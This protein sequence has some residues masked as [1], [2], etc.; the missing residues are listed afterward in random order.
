MRSRNMP[1][2]RFF[3]RDKLERLLDTLG[4]RFALFDAVP[5]PAQPAGAQAKRLWDTTCSTCHGPDGGVSAFGRTLLPAPPDLRHFSLTPER[6][7]AVI[8]DGYPGT[9]M[10][11]IFQSNKMTRK[12][13]SA[14][15]SK[16]RASSPERAICTTKRREVR[17]SCRICREV[18]LSSTTS[19]EVPARAVGCSKHNACPVCPRG[20]STVKWNRAPCSGWLSTSS[21]PPMLTTAW[22]LA[23]FG[24]K[25]AYVY[26]LAVFVVG[27]ILGG[28]S[29]NEHV[30]I[31]ARVL[32]GA[33]AGLVQP[34]AMPPAGE[35]ISGIDPV[36]PVV[37]DQQDT[38]GRQLAGPALKRQ[39]GRWRN[40]GPGYGEG[41][42]EPKDAA[43]TGAALHG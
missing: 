25:K 6:A 5:A 40:L 20:N 13:F 3:D 2:F 15:S 4:A 9:V 10:P 18:A 33:A 28:V 35:Q 34:V 31:V 43:L 21:T 12:S 19:T 17:I 37:L 23:T 8:T 41:A 26:A 29:P 38:Q 11:G 27:S 14:V 32:Q 1:Y 16:R 36:D 7:L 30:L 22:G 24:T 42:D 39:P